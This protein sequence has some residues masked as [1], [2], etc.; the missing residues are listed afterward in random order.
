MC[1]S[2]WSE[3]RCVFEFEG[4]E[5]GYALANHGLY[6]HIVKYKWNMTMVLCAKSSIFKMWLKS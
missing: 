3:C 2:V 1:M 5:M 6:F 4:C